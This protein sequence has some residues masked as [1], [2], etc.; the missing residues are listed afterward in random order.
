MSFLGL[1]SSE[2][3][4]GKRTVRGSITKTGNRH[5]RRLLVEAAWHYQ[6]PPRLSARIRARKGYAT[7]EAFARAWQAQIRLHARYRHLSGIRQALHG[8]RR[9][10][11]PRARRL[12]LGGDAPPSR[13]E[14]SLPGLLPQ[15][16]RRVPPA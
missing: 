1:T 3:S 11:R 15:P 5:A 8:G 12:S 2:Y 7:P 13:C 6:H 16:E 14:T 10:R 4:S 9:R